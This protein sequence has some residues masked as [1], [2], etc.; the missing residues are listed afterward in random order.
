MK[1]KDKLQLVNL[2]HIYMDELGE[3]LLDTERNSEKFEYKIQ[4]EFADIIATKL[5]KELN[6][7]MDSYELREDE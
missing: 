7:R 2:L 3:K 1:S 5:S 6:N 4:Y